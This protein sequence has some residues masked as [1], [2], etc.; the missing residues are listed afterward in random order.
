MVGDRVRVRVTLHP[1][2]LEAILR[3]GVRWGLGGGG[4]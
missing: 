4:G 3:M 1:Q 2:C